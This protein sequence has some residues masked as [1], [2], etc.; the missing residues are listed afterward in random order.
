MLA[1][2]MIN[3]AQE[4]GA[5]WAIIAEALG[6]PNAKAAKNDVKK[7]ARRLEKALRKEVAGGDD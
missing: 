5:T 7:V 3:D 1:L 6:Y 2:R 4:S